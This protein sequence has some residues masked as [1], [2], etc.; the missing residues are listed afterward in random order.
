V[1]RTTASHTRK[2]SGVSFSITSWLRELLE[3]ELG[4]AAMDQDLIVDVFLG[5]RR[6]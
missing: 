1:S 6:L 4:D 5:R 3:R 2:F